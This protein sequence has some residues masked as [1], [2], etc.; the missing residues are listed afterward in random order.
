M[1]AALLKG[2]GMFMEQA[3]G[4]TVV[5]EKLPR[6][7]GLSGS[8]VKLIAIAL[9]AVDHIGMAILERM[10]VEGGVLDLETP[11]QITA[12][13]TQYGALYRTDLVL[14]LAGSIAFPLFCFLL[15]EGFLHTRSVKRYALRLAAF[16]LISEIPFDLAVAGS[17]WEPSVQNVYFTLLAGLLTIWAL[18]ALARHPGWPGWGRVL[19][20]LAVCAASM[21]LTTLMHSDYD[22]VGVLMIVLFYLLRRRRVAAAGLGCAVLLA[23]SVTQASGNVALRMMSFT[24]T[25][26]FLALIPIALYNG[27]RGPRLKYFFYWFYP[28][29][30]LMLWLVCVGM[31]IA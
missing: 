22:S 3:S 2:S 11:G 10:M 24:P 5:A 21:S 9:M 26:S 19:A 15:V 25:T 31:G 20:G 28:V 13:W 17:T 4:Q 16:A 18:D 8:A 14:R 29:H 23:R 12:F 30:L 27:R 6:Q 1:G 7:G